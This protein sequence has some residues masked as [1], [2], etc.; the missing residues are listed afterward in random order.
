MDYFMMHVQRKFRSFIHLLKI[1]RFFYI[2]NKKKIEYCNDILS[3]VELTSKII[4]TNS[5][6]KCYTL[7]QIIIIFNFT[8]VHLSIV[9]S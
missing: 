5:H 2:K 7:T 9:F 1:Q 8:L 4:Y 6:T 3:C